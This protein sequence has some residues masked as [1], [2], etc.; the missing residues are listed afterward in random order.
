MLFALALLTSR[1]GRPL[2]RASLLLLVA[3]LDA[4]QFVMQTA[5]VSGVEV[6]A[7]EMQ[8]ALALL[9]YNRTLCRVGDRIS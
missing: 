9:R 8:M 2:R 1:F 5:N 7:S 4:R 6:A 3:T